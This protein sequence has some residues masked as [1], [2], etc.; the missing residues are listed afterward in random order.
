MNMWVER[1]DTTAVAGNL[2]GDK[3][4]ADL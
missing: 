4:K 1:L 3:N 2:T